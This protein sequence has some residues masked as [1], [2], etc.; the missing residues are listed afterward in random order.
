MDQKKKKAFRE[1]L[2][3]KR[4]EILVAVAQTK[5][6]G[7]EAEP[8]GAQDVADMA[9]SAS[10]KEF[11]WSLS[12]TERETLQLVDDALERLARHRFGTCVSCEEEMNPKRLEA[13]PWARHCLRCQEMQ[14]Q[15]LL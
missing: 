3:K 7:L 6:H 5:R 12:T 9:S 2:L 11:L 15:G 13:V 8:A 4:G 10:T 1:R 14:E